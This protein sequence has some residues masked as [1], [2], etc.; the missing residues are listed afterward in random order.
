MSEIPRK[1]LFRV[2][3]LPKKEAKVS[4]NTGLYQENPENH[5]D[6]LKKEAAAEIIGN[7]VEFWHSWVRS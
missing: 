3:E 1:S 2:A 6:L 5:E 4:G 7:T